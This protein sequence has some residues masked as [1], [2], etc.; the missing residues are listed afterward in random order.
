MKLINNQLHNR[1]TE[2]SLSNLMKTVIESPEKVTDS[3][4]EEI[5]DVW[6]DCCVNSHSDSYLVTYAYLT[7]HAL[8]QALIISNEFY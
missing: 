2:I 6:M 3:D 7:D 1:L 5:V 8:C 4:L